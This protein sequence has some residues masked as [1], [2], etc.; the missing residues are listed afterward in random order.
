[1]GLPVP[2]VDRGAAPLS[3]ALGTVIG[4]VAARIQRDHGVDLRCGA[5]VEALEDDDA[6][7]LAQAWLSDG[8]VMNVDVAVA[9]LGSIR[10][11]ERL[12]SSG[13]AAGVWGVACDAGCRVQDANSDCTAEAGGTPM[14]KR[15]QTAVAR[16]I[17]RFRPP[18]TTLSSH[19]CASSSQPAPMA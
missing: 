2:L 8:S 19:S 4:R 10:N 12:E 7:R 3:G 14:Y 5:Q 11:V 15:G 16:T 17:L 9:A 13:L 18:S 1:M 6:G